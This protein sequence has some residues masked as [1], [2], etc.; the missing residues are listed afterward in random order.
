ARAARRGRVAADWEAAGQTSA[1][2]KSAA[3]GRKSI[4]EQF[5]DRL[6]ALVHDADGPADRRLVL[7]GV[8]D[9]EHLADRRQEVQRRGGP[10]DHLRP[11]LVC[12][13][14]RQPALDAAADQHA[15]PGPRVVVAARL[16]ATL[17]DLRRPAE[18]AHPDH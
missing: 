7:L 12:L 17:V 9:A 3:T 11:F 1:D 4:S 2:S 18:L 8:V 16:V 15:A 13:A 14:D 10:L 5:L 6:G